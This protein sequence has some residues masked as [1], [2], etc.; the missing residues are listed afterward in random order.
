MGEMKEQEDSVGF[1]GDTDCF[2]GGEYDPESCSVRDTLQLVGGDLSC[3]GV[4]DFSHA[5]IACVKFLYLGIR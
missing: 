3:A 5:I 2:S 1:D 4:D